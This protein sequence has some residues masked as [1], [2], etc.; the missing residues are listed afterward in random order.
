TIAVPVI[1]LRVERC[2]HVVVRA[3]HTPHHGVVQSAVHVD[4]AKLRHVLMAGIATVEVGGQRGCGCSVPVRSI[5]GATPWVEALCDYYRALII[6]QRGQA[7]EVVL[8][9]IVQ[10]GCL[11]GRIVGEQVAEAAAAG[12]VISYIL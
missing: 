6:R 1:A 5:A 3:E 12:L 7:T 9:S 8:V 4:Q 11:R 2:L 10:L